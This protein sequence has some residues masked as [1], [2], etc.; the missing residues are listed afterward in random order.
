MFFY[1]RL[2]PKSFALFCSHRDPNFKGGLGQVSTLH[3][4]QVC[5]E[6][7]LFTCLNLT[8]DSPSY[9]NSRD[10]FS[11]NYI[12]FSNGYASSSPLVCI[13]LVPRGFVCTCNNNVQN[14]T[15]WKVRI[16]NLIYVARA[17]RE[18]TY[19]ANF[20]S[21]GSVSYT[22]CIITTH[23][24]VIVCSTMI[25]VRKRKKE[26]YD[27]IIEVRHN[28]DA[29][30]LSWTAMS[31]KS[32]GVSIP[33]VVSVWLHQAHSDW[34]QD[35]CFG[36]S[37]ATCLV[38]GEL[39]VVCQLVLC[40]NIVYSAEQDAEPNG[41]YDVRDIPNTWGYWINRCSSHDSSTGSR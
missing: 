34:S 39:S 21:R 2:A 10:W 1:F 31:S 23:L 22:T 27:H 33:V 36:S 28:D 8:A 9:G 38:F 37:H 29:N 32:S 6:Q 40:F 4:Y 16:Q 41:P 17:V 18:K 25:P 5:A 12:K 13:A 26:L 14:S 30:W 20:E 11:W 15:T 24:S 35:M 3:Q 7:L 19:L